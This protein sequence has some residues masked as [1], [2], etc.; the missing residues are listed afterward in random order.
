MILQEQQLEQLWLVEQQNIVLDS[1]ENDIQPI[2]DI[3]N[4]TDINVYG[5]HYSDGEYQS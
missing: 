5:E 1:P 3:D 4:E 2:S